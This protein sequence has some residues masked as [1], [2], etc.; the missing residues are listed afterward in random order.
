LLVRKPTIRSLKYILIYI[1]G[2]GVW[3]IELTSA[4]KSSMKRFKASVGAWSVKLH[5]K[6]RFKV[7]QQADHQTWIRAMWDRTLH[8]FV[9]QLDDMTFG[10]SLRSNV[11]TDCFCFRSCF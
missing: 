4:M 10:S 3:N 9:N 5:P 11:G 8:N 2:N 1:K 7:T 6:M